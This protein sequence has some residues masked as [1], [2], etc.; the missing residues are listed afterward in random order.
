MPGNVLRKLDQLAVRIGLANLE[1]QKRRMKSNV[2]FEDIPFEP[3]AD[4]LYRM[5]ISMPC[6]RGKR[7]GKGGKKKGSGGKRGGRK[8]Y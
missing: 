3:D 8:G 1:R 6:K 7:G 4:G 5:E 2:A